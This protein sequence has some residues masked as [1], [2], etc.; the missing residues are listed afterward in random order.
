[1]AYESGMIGLD[2]IVRS[3]DAHPRLV[4]ILSYIEVALMQWTQDSGV[5]KEWLFRLA[6]D[7]RKVM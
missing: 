2:T 6:R 4:K 7:W 3:F 5:D 1:M